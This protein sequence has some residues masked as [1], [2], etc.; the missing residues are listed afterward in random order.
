MNIVEFAE[1][2]NLPGVQ[3]CIKNGDDVEYKDKYGDTALSWAAWNGHTEIVRYL[4][5]EGG[6]DVESKDKYGNTALNWAAS[7]SCTETIRCLLVEGGADIEV[8]NDYG[9][10]ALIAA[11]CNDCTETV[12]CLLIEGGAD[13][14]AMNKNGNTALICAVCNGHTEIA[15][16][17]QEEIE[18]RK[19]YRV[20]IYSFLICQWRSR[21]QPCLHYNQTLPLQCLPELPAHLIAREMKIKFIQNR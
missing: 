9:N 12:R 5:V 16:L 13:I 8:K 18:R 2:G 17:I 6:A 7:N 11:V 19:R 3:Q 1:K 4:T 21:Q 14:E 20:A 10:T 15:I